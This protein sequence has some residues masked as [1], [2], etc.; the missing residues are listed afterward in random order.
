MCMWD[1]GG[2]QGRC[3]ATQLSLGVNLQRHAYWG[4]MCECACV[5]DGASTAD[6]K[7]KKKKTDRS[8]PSHVA[9][10]MNNTAHWSVTAVLPL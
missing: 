5:T 4:R 7:K 9:A 10:K 2:C 3:V 8:L 1:S 6:W